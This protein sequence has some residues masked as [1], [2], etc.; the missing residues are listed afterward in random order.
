MALKSSE[1]HW[2][3]HNYIGVDGGYLGDFSYSTH[4][5][6]YPGF[7][8]LTID[9]DT[10]PGTT[11]ARFV[12]I[13]TEASDAD[14]VAILRGVARRFPIGSEM[15]RSAAAHQQLLKLAARCADEASVGQVDIQVTAFAVRQALKDAELLLERHGPVSAVDRMHTAMH[16]YMKALCVAA[17]AELP[18]NAR[19]GALFK[20]LRKHHPLFDANSAHS[21]TV[22]RVLGS[23]SG[24]MEALDA[25]RNSG[26]LAHANDDLLGK[27]EA[28]LM[29]NAS[30]A[31]FQYLSAKVPL[32]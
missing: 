31:L 29:I 28:V 15:Q 26:S 16:G 1:I 4:R 11:K 5:E 17:G 32:V 22:E 9:P 21:E 2:L 20:L 23:L 6:F 14:Q 3:V 30:R 8:D 25:A 24:M 13:L 27:D 18:V 19:M 7:C 12:R 10:L